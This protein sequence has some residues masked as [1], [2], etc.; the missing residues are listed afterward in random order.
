MEKQNTPLKM[1]INEI[2]K[3]KD[4]FDFISISEVIEILDKLLPI[5]REVIEKAHWNG[6]FGNGCNGN[7][8]EYFENNFNPNQNS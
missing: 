6:E 7:S 8:T 3:D 1:A 4:S 5:E 2:K